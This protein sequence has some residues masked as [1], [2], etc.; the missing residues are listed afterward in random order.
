MASTLSFCVQYS[1]R[2][3]PSDLEDPVDGDAELLAHDGLFQD[4]D[5]TNLV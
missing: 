2:N 4:S 5:G 3:L 1:I